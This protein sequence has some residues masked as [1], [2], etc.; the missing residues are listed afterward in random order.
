MRLA[1]VSEK[2]MVP[3]IVIVGVGQGGEEHP[4][5]FAS[6][7]SKLNPDVCAKVNVDKGASPEPVVT[8]AG[9]VHRVKVQPAKDE[10][11]QVVVPIVTLTLE[12]INAS[13]V[14]GAAKLESP[15]ANPIAHAET[16]Y[17]FLILSS[18]ASLVVASPQKVQPVAQIRQYVGRRVHLLRQSMKSDS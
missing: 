14:E 4:V 11:H 6:L 12:I 17:L 16:K 9:N 13:L 2:A 18:H 10:S 3:L 8:D 7:V 5:P 15:I 1:D